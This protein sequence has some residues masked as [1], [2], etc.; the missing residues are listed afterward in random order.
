MQ[1]ILSSLQQLNRPRLLVRTAKTVAQTYKR[2]RHL[3]QIFH[4]SALPKHGAALLRLIEIEQTINE[5]RQQKH[6]GYSLARHIEILAAL[7]GE[8]QLFRAAH[9]DK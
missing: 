2:D 1:D 7:M 3:K 9:S 6:A 4:S 5:M 8:T